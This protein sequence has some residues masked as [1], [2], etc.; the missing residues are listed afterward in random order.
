MLLIFV[1]LLLTQ[2]VGGFPIIKEKLLPRGTPRHPGAIESYLFPMFNDNNAGEP[3]VEQNW[4]IFYPKT[5]A[6]HSNTQTDL[7]DNPCPSLKME[8][9]FIGN[10]DKS[11]CSKCGL[12]ETMC[13][14]DITFFTNQNREWNEELFGK[15]I[16]NVEDINKKCSVYKDKYNGKTNSNDISR[17]NQCKNYLLSLIKSVSGSPPRCLYDNLFKTNNYATCA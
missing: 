3:D 2:I 12:F 11:K 9:I 7:P 17:Q 4:G 6:T 13:Y 15:F 8:D 10:K 1:L 14:L 5:K 16:E